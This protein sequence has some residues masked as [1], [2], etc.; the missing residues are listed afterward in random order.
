MVRSPSSRLELL[1]IHTSGLLLTKHL[2]LLVNFEKGC[3]LGQ[4]LTARAKFVGATRKRLMPL[5]ITPKLT[6]DATYVNQYFQVRWGLRGGVIGIRM[7]LRSF[8]SCSFI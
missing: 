7:H 2:S 4:E 1:E 5:R 6:P 3:Y 8:I